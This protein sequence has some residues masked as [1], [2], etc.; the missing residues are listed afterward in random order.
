VGA[1]S[2]H[3]PPIRSPTQPHPPAPPTYP[4]TQKGKAPRPP[5]PRATAGP[6][7]AR[8]PK[9]SVNLSRTARPGGHFYRII[10]CKMLHTREEGVIIVSYETILVTLWR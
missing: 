9:Q 3:P 1:G 8:P 6:A 7:R 2:S 5:A 10:C 4:I